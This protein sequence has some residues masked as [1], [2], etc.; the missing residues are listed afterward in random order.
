MLFKR[1]TETFWHY[2]WSAVRLLKKDDER[3]IKDLLPESRYASSFATL[4]EFSRLDSNRNSPLSGMGLLYGPTHTLAQAALAAS[5]G[6][7]YNERKEEPG[8]KCVQCGEFEVLHTTSYQSGMKARDYAEGIKSFW[9]DLS[10]HWPNTLDFEEDDTSAEHLC[11][12]CFIKRVAYRVLENKNEHILHEVCKG[13]GG[14]P[15]TTEIALHSWFIRQGISN[16]KERREQAQKIHMED[17]NIDSRTIK[18]RYYAI[19]Y[20]D[21]DRMGRLVGGETI[22]SEWKSVLQ[23]TL[24]DRMTSKDFARDYRDCWNSI[25]SKYPRR[26]LTPAIHA[27]ISESLG[28]FALYGVAPTIEKYEGKLIYAGGDDVCAFLPVEHAIKAAF[29][30]R[31]YYHR[32]FQIVGDDGRGMPITEWNGGK[33]K[34][35][36]NLGK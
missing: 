14:F 24:I 15:S 26:L 6:V 27:A 32:F 11:A 2:D 4:E 36:I 8:E 30:I 21:G 28:D 18:D 35:S 20:M 3:T 1:Q 16:E 17:E 5:K 19:L 31:D 22:G 13:L 34:I 29:E 33:G 9:K 25:F 23:K 12:N 7:R 10:A